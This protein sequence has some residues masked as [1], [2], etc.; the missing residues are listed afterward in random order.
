M[1]REIWRTY[2]LGDKVDLV[3]RLLDRGVLADPDRKI[4]RN[5][6]PSRCCVQGCGPQ[7]HEIAKAAE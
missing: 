5:R 1:K 2:N 3:E 7:A 4:T 6:Q